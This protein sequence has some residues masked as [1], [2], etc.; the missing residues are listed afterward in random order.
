[1]EGLLSTGLPSLVLDSTEEKLRAVCKNCPSR[2]SQGTPLPGDSVNAPNNFWG[3]N[4][5]LP[6]KGFVASSKEPLRLV[7]QENLNTVTAGDANEDVGPTACGAKKSLISFT[8]IHCFA[9]PA[10]RLRLLL[11]Q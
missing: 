11:R 10:L 7:A 1:M 4:Q 2:R 6:T 9:P 8:A 3:A 5:K